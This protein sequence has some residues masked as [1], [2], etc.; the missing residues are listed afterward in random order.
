MDNA[1]RNFHNGNF[2]LISVNVCVGNGQASKNN[3]IYIFLNFSNLKML[4]YYLGQF[5]Q[6]ILKIINFPDFCGD[7]TTVALF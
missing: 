4:F 2:F 7:A 3:Q 1:I 6:E 5:N